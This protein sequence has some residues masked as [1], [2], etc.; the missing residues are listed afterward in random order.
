MAGARSLRSAVDAQ[1]GRRR[2]LRA[3]ARIR[4]ARRHRPRL[5][6]RHCAG[7]PQ[8][9]GPARRLLYR[10]AFQQ[11]DAGDAAPRDVRL[12]RA[13][14]RH[15]DR[16]LCR[17]PAAVAV[18]V[19]GGDRHHHLGRRRLRARGDRRGATRWGCAS[20]RPAQRED[21]LQGARALAGES[22]GAARRRQEGSRRTHG[23]DPPPGSDKQQTCRSMPRLRRSRKKR[24]R[25]MW[26]GIRNARLTEP[27]ASD[28][29]G[30]LRAG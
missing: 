5:A 11:S 12:A 18:A 10:R 19:A 28:F 29:V 6:V 13:L 21:Q 3:E 24:Y 30:F 4:A 14:H 9:A 8:H 22:P 23:L 16:A 1:Q 26:P 25:R 27:P 17:P 20:R 2:L 15:H 7:R